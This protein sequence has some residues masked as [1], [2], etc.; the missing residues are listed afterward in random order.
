MATRSLAAVGR[1]GWQ[2]S[3]ALATD[4][5]VTLVFGGEHFQGW[6]DD[7]TTETQNQ[8]EGRFL[9]DVVVAQSS[10]IFELLPRKDEPLLVRGDP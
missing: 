10:A 9:L 5:L 6:L 2:T 1:T 7:A 3:I 8:M 4:L